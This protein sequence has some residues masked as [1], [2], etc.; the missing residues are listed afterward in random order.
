MGCADGIWTKIK[1]WL[2]KRK[3]SDLNKSLINK[4]DKD[5]Q[6]NLKLVIT[7]GPPD[8]FLIELRETSNDEI[9]KFPFTLN[10]KK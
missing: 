5:D 10:Y 4:S 2:Y 6:G 7:A 3:K 8:E 9:K 1:I